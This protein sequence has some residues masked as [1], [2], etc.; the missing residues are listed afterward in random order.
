MFTGNY[1]GTPTQLWASVKPNNASFL[2]GNRG[3]QSYHR[4]CWSVSACVQY[5]VLLPGSLA[6]QK[7]EQE[8]IQRII[9]TGKIIGAELPYITTISSRCLQL[10]I[11]TDSSHS[12]HHLFQ[13]LPSGNRF[14]SI[15]AMTCG[16][17]NS[18]HPQAI[19]LLN[20]SHTQLFLALN[21]IK[22]ICIYY[23]NFTIYLSFISYY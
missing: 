1:P 19:R 13:L 15:K 4:D 23:F 17:T 5:K 14:R 2:S 20:G 18:F 8:A 16:M 6:A 10:P 22:L 7:E 21:Y 12:A 3:K 9:K 11:L